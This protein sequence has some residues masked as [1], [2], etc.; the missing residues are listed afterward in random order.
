VLANKAF[1]LSYVPP[2]VH[3]PVGVLYPRGYAMSRGIFEKQK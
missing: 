1:I 2:S 3:I